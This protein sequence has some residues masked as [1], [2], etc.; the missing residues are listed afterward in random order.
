M[1]RRQVGRRRWAT[2]CPRQHPWLGPVH[3]HDHV[4]PDVRDADGV[5][6]P[7]PP[8]QHGPRCVHAPGRLPGRRPRSRDRPRSP[9]R[10]PKT[11]PR[12]PR[13]GD[14]RPRTDG[15][16][17][18][19]TCPTQRRSPILT[20]STRMVA[21]PGPPTP[22]P[23]RARTSRAVTTA[24]MASAA[25]AGYRALRSRF[26]RCGRRTADR[27]HLRRG[28]RR[29]RGAAPRR[30][31]QLAGPAGHPTSATRP[32][33]SSGPTASRHPT[34]P[35]GPNAGPDPAMWSTWRRMRRRVLPRHEGHDDH[36]RGRPVDRDGD[37]VAC[38]RTLLSSHRC[39]PGRDVAA[40]RARRHPTATHPVGAA[41][42]A[43]AGGRWSS[44]VVSG[45]MDRRWD[46]G[47]CRSPVGSLVVRRPPRRRLKPRL[48]PRH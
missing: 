46:R 13:S 36:G 24:R 27:R 14:R 17:P 34:A 35:H 11:R 33:T 1:A 43:V 39:H 41:G 4:H 16:R 5:R 25:S 45:G 40:R 18:V 47:R 30:S 10:R 15:R 31:V 32:R 22:G 19:G 29:G 21:P 3:V 6:C 28:Q 12:R 44:N 8:H 42:A 9:D 23:R 38:R 7:P 2:T 48:R 37:D 20:M 26:H